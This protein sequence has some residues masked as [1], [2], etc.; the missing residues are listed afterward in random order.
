MKL[1]SIFTKFIVRT[2]VVDLLYYICSNDSYKICFAN[3]SK[4]LEILVLCQKM[5]QNPLLAKNLLTTL[6]SLSWYKVWVRITLFCHPWNYSFLCPSLKYV[7]YVILCAQHLNTIW[8][9]LIIF[10]SS[11]TSWEEDML[12]SLGNWF[13][14]ICSF[15]AKFVAAK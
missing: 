5:Y 1:I 3:V 14:F 12:I 8:S 4:I 7:W 9:N 10:S 6:Y 15:A 11:G 13:F 2:S